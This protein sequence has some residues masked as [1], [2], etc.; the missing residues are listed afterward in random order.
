MIKSLIAVN[1]ENAD[2]AALLL[3][4]MYRMLSHAC[5]YYIFSTEAPFSAVGY[6]Q[7]NLLDTVLAK[8]FSNGFTQDSIRLAIYTVLESNVDRETLHASL[9]YCLLRCLKTAEA[10]QIALEECIYYVDNYMD[11]HMSPYSSRRF[12]I[13]YGSDSIG[14][15][16]ADEAIGQ[17]AELYLL[18]TIGLHVCDQGVKFFK[19][20]Y[21]SKNNKEVGLYVLLRILGSYIDDD[22]EMVDIWISVYEK[23]ITAG[24][25]PRDELVIAYREITAR[26]LAD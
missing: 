9:H 8:L 22:D 18:I 13:S 10:K 26:R 6:E 19:K 1:G 24:I 7:A 16:R 12:L 2:S 11:S 23:A 4:E 3:V 17:C 21:P 25:I 5:S 15:F 14:R 20:Y